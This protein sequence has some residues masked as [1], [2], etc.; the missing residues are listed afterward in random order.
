MPHLFGNNIC[1]VPSEKNEKDLNTLPEAV[2]GHGGVLE[3]EVAG[4][5]HQTCKT[6]PKLTSSVKQ[7]Q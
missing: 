3:E 4:T 1:I 7:S 6:K 5:R 2:E